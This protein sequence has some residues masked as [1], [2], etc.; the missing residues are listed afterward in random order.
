MPVDVSAPFPM[1][2]YYQIL[3]VPSSATIQELRRA[4]RIL[5]RRYHPDVNPGEGSEARFKAIA[6]AYGILSDAEK[7]K[8]YDLK[9]EAFIKAKMTRGQRAYEQQDRAG[10]SPGTAT[11][12]ASRTY[13]AAQERL[14]VHTRGSQPKPKQESVL[15]QPGL[16]EFA[17]QHV[18]RGVRGALNWVRGQAGPFPGSADNLPRVSIME[19]S[20]SLRD[21]IYG[22]R[23][24]IEV[25][26]PRGARKISV[27]IPLG[28]R[29]GGVV[30][31]KAKAGTHEEMIFI[32]RIAAHPIL[33]LQDKGLVAEIP[34]SISE[35]LFGASITVPTLDEQVIVRIPPGVQSGQEIR[36]KQRG[37]PLREGGRGDLFL[38]L[39][40]KIPEDKD[41][42]G[43]RE[44]VAAL[45]Q[46]YAKPVRQGFPQHLLD[47]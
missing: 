33:S 25:P 37:A 11:A 20:I 16:A 22:T 9:L 14:R 3:G 35:A 21:A 5:A 40:V 15:R 38:R 18:A 28:I 24:T 10:P 19:V 17:R 31:L 4:Y 45:E 46:H 36:L 30:R 39:I 26:D 12:Q 23:K 6:N 34:I 8:Q 32:V 47:V 29:N 42:F 41:A 43:I 7:R 27:R 1:D 44:K 13:D 2:N